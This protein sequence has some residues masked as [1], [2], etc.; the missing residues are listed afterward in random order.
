M[1]K[2]IYNHFNFV[3]LKIQHLYRNTSYSVYSCV[4]A[5]L[6]GILNNLVEKREKVQQLKWQ[7]LTIIISYAWHREYCSK[8][9]TSI[10]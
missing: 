2:H 7:K 6:I 10:A 4:V 9:Q 5:G 3:G 1:D 8:T